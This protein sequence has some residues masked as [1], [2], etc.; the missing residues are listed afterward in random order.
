MPALA[1]L[2][3]RSH[4]WVRSPE[5]A[6]FHPPEHIADLEPRPRYSAPAYI[7]LLRETGRTV[8]AIAVDG[9]PRHARDAREFLDGEEMPMTRGWNFDRSRPRPIFSNFREPVIAVDKS[10]QH[11]WDEVFEK[12]R[13]LAKF[14]LEDAFLTRGFAIRVSGRD[15]VQAK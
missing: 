11:I 2:A 7:I 6:C 5:R 13:I 3:D 4:K 1:G 10:G 14:S 12:V 8:A 15:M 9:A